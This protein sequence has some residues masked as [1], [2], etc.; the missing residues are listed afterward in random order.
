MVHAGL[1]EEAGSAFSGLQ[2]SPTS[3]PR[4]LL[5]H[6]SFVVL[7]GRQLNVKVRFLSHW[8]AGPGTEYKRS[9]LFLV[10]V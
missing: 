3:V 4:V 2:E 8:L 10:P 9:G 7:R 1:V 5:C 6:D